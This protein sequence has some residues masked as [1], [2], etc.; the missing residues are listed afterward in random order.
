MQEAISPGVLRSRM[1]GQ[2]QIA[3]LKGAALDLSA[4]RLEPLQGLAAVHKDD[5]A[6]RR[7]LKNAAHCSW[8]ATSLAASTCSAWTS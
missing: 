4:L 7:D 3:R 6:M 5:H 8:M 2:A 1:R